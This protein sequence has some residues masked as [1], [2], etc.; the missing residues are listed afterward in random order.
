MYASF[1]ITNNTFKQ[2]TQF[3]TSMQMK[4]QLISKDYMHNRTSRWD[5]RAHIYT[6]LYT[7]YCSL[8]SAV[9][10]TTGYGLHGRVGV[11]VPVGERIF[12][13]PYCSDRPLGSTQPR[14]HWILAW[15]KAADAWSWP[16]TSSWCRGQED[17]DLQ[18]HS[19][20]G[21]HGEMFIN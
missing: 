14:I 5:H 1:E 9:G 4:M 20:I 2:I 18:I 13:S 19:P 10:I 16:L 17:V 8:S 6:G 15:C 3:S 11:R 12:A 7:L 21:F